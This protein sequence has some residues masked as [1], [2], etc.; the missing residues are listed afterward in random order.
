MT[1]AAYGDGAYNVVYLLHIISIIVATGAAFILPIVASRTAASGQST[2]VVDGVTAAV[3]APSLVAAG[4]FGGAL[5]GLSSDVYDFSQAWLSI[6][7]FFWIVAIA[8]AALAFPPSYSPL[9][10][11]SDKLPMLNGILHLS[12]AIMLVIMTWKFGA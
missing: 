1:F 3:L 2:A 4:V 9:P 8:A 10:D 5:V 6:G 11:M 7:G 12:L